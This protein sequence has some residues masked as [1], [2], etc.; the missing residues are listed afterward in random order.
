[1][2]YTH[3]GDQ[4]SGVAAARSNGV[5]VERGEGFVG[6][7]GGTRSAA[8]GVAEIPVAARVLQPFGRVPGSVAANI[9]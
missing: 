7:S 6:T 4:Q 3:D 8:H 9:T 5:D 2:T 1:M